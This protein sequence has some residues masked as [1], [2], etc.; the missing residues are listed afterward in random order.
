[1]KTVLKNCVVCLSIFLH[2][3]TLFGDS[4]PFE[5]RNGLVV[6]KATINNVEGNFILDTGSSDLL[7]NERVF[8]NNTTFA[9]AS[10][11]VAGEQIKID[12]LHIGKTHFQAVE[13]YRMNLKSV[14]EYVEDEIK[15]II[16]ARLLKPYGVVID[17]S[18]NYL[19][20]ITYG[21]DHHITE[22]MVSL[23]FEMISNVPVVEVKI[24]DSTYRFILD[25][26]ATSH[27]VDQAVIERYKG[28]FDDT[29]RDAR[30]FSTGDNRGIAKIYQMHYLIIGDSVNKNIKIVSGEFR[31]LIPDTQ[32]SGLISMWKLSDD[33]IYLDNKHDVVYFE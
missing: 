3:T 32:I 12:N 33:R 23:P 11:D 13:A 22:H 14:S 27:F 15:G 17:F 28:L 31:H 29:G 1:M 9:T 16:G 7:I 8:S 30:T 24:N 2:T 20:L 4:I 6:I 18:K 26:G 10:N 5:V 21:E 19:R 25:S